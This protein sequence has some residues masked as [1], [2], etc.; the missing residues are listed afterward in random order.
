[1]T[2]SAVVLLFGLWMP[3]FGQGSPPRS[4][5]DIFSTLRSAARFGRFPTDD[6]LSELGFRQSA[7]AGVEIN[8]EAGGCSSSSQV[9]TETS[10]A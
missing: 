8:S 10:S 1:M 6:Q 7:D 4:T 2:Y 3:V 9:I 5:E